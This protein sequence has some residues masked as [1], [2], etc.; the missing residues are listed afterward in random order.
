M[1][2]V[3]GQPRPIGAGR[4]KKI[5]PQGLD[6]VTLMCMAGMTPDPWQIRVATTHGD[7]LLLCHRQAGKST[8]VAAIALADALREKDSLILL[9]SRSMRQSGELFRKVKR[10]YNL[11]HP[12]P[13]SKDTEHAL[14][15]SNGSRIISLPA[16]E[17]TIVGY[18]AV[19]R[20]ILD[21]AARIPDGTYY[22]VRPMLAMSQGSL[23][24]L[25]SPFGRRGFF[26]EAWEGTIAEQQAL[27]VATV[28][29][30]LAD[31][32]FPIEEFSDETPLPA[33]P[34]FDE[35][36]SFTWTRTFLPCTHNPR[37]A[38]RRRFLAHERRSIP[39]LWFRQEWLCEFVELGQVVF[40]F[41]DLQAMMSTQVQPLYGPDGMLLPESPLVVREDVERLT[42]GN[43]VWT[44]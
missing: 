14:E 4:R 40:R 9:L 19:T 10:F 8:I 28:E 18:S 32:H 34:S 20:L 39:D 26:Y 6:A 11:V 17:E 31:L 5:E 44:D 37:M 12:L 38:Q 33:S 36:Q 22:A 16:S 1:P 7:Q 43:G 24:A 41:E 21:E 2:F 13:L 30:L 29:H 25:S 27:D 35:T 3:K 23:L 15:L 42:V